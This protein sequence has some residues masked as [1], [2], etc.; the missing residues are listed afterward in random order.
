M[1]RQERE[2]EKSNQTLPNESNRQTQ[3]IRTVQEELKLERLRKEHETTLYSFEQSNRIY[4]ETM[5]P[6]RGETFYQ[7]EVFRHSLVQLLKEEERGQGLFYL[8][9]NKEGTLIGRLNLTISGETADV[10][11]R[12]GEAFSG[13]GYA[14]KALALA[15][16]EAQ[17]HLHLQKITAKTTSAHIASQTVLVK[18]GFYEVRRDKEIFMWKGK[19]QQF[20][21]YERLLT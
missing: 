11:Y 17:R 15:I 3:S 20:V 9:F 8:I 14:K 19:E 10:G 4:F 1:E 16:E 5:V 18:N 13:R 12:I 21:Y 7:K 6:S 2:S